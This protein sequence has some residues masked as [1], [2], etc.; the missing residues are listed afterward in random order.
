[1]PMRA[2]VEENRTEQN[3]IPYSDCV[4]QIHREKTHKRDQKYLLF[5]V[6]TSAFIL[7]YET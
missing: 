1:M 3:H 7:F 4:G 2:R 6:V 5:L